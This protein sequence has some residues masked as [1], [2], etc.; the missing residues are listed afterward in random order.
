MNVALYSWNEGRFLA[1]DQNG[2]CCATLFRPEN[3]DNTRTCERFKVVDAGDGQVALYNIWHQRF[4]R[5]NGDDVDG[6]GGPVGQLDPSW[7]LEKFSPVLHPSGAVA[8]YCGAAQRF[9]RIMGES[10][11]ARGG[12]VENGPCLPDNWFSEL[13]FVIPHDI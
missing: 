2:R 13:L 9:V 1:M 8:L 6:L 7:V 3:L 10:V 4:L 11:D 12:P 5:V